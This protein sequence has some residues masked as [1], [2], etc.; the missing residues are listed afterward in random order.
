[1]REFMIVSQI[2]KTIDI[3]LNYYEV[4]ND[5]QPLVLLHAQGV[6][7]LSFEKTFAALSQKYH[8]YAIDC[9][10]HGGSLHNKER[11]NISDIGEAII[12]FIENVIKG[13]VWLLGHSSGG[14]IAAYIA[15]ES[16]LCERLILED[17]PFFSSQGERR[18]QSFNYIDLSTICHTF[19]TQTTSK[20]F[21]LYYFANQYAW[22]FFPE[23]SR[24]KVRGKLVASAAKYRAK[25]PDK[26][27]KVMFW[28]KAALNAYQGMNLYDPLFGEA[29]YDDS[30]HNDIPHEDILSNIKCK[31]VFLKAKTEI[32]NDGIL[33]AAL[34]EEDLQ[35]VCSLVKDCTVVRFDCGH[36]IHMEK[37]K[38]FI[39]CLMKLE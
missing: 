9:Y 29:F 32:N 1:M 10:G 35:K 7:A 17:P 4:K 6:D 11:Y 22:N 15:A 12:D 26:N 3:K 39:D 36:G 16:H 38:E 23:K 28:P 37:K 33:M 14:L 31:T 2:Y 25:H 13:K 20:D 18:K 30:F 27:L 24:E 8:I 34:S 21:V 19:N 5:L